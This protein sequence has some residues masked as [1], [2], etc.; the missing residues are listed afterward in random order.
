MVQEK[1][2]LGVEL[3]PSSTITAR[4]IQRRSNSTPLISELGCFVTSDLHLQQI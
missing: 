1:M 2:E 3:L 4:N